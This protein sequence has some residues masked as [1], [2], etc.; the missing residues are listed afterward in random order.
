MA[1]P[2]R[3]DKD[4]VLVLR[5]LLLEQSVQIK[6]TT[7]F[8]ALFFLLR[9]VAAF[10]SLC[11]CLC[12]CVFKRQC[13]YKDMNSGKKK[14]KRRRHRKSYLALIIT[15]VKNCK[16]KTAPCGRYCCTCAAFSFNSFICR[17]VT[18]T[19]FLVFSSLSYLFKLSAFSIS[20]SLTR[21]LSISLSSHALVIRTHTHS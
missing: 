7:T 17:H 19:S 6:V 14:S 11:V 3:S 1:L 20:L 9:A 16:S 13:A 8:Y 12:E 5:V 18:T 4:V 21:S 2:D 10:F 15:I